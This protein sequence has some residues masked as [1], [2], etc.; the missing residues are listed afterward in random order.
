MF[1]V[2]ETSECGMLMKYAS[3]KY[4]EMIYFPNASSALR[5]FLQKVFRNMNVRQNNYYCLCL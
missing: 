2:V 3:T 1:G 4:I 5:K